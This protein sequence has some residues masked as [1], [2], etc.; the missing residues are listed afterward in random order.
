MP[1]PESKGHDSVVATVV[2]GSAAVFIMQRGVVTDSVV[3][4]FN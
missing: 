3:S 2:I 1:R 4:K